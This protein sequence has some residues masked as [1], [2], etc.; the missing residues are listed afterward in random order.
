MGKQMYLTEEEQRIVPQLLNG[1][2]SILL[3]RMDEGVENP[4]IDGKVNVQGE[5]REIIFSISA[6]STK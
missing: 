2:T 6:K 1:I 4:T 3:E 5:D